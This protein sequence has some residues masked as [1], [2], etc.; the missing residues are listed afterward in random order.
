MDMGVAVQHVGDVDGVVGRHRDRRIPA[1]LRQP[2]PDAASVV[3]VTDRA[4]DGDRPAEAPAAV[5][6]AG[7]PDPVAADPGHIDIAAIDGLLSLRVLPP[8][9]PADLTN[10]PDVRPV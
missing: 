2:E 9:T 1:V 10:R 8:A 5:G 7:E 6:G 3:A 4:G